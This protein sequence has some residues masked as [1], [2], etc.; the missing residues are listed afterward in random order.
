MIDH[1]NAFISYR[2]APLDS[3]VAAEVQKQLERFRIPIAIRK[4]SGIRKIDRI[5]RDK[6]ELLITSD[7]NETIQQALLHS[8]FLIVICS[9]STRESVW[10]QREIEFFLTTHERSQVLT[11]VAEGEPVDVVPQILQQQEVTVTL[12]SGETETVC[13]PM[14]PLSCDYRGNFRKAR[15]EELPRLAAAMLGCSYDELKRRQRQYR[16]RQLALTFSAVAAGLIALSVYYAWSANQIQKNYEQALINQSQYLSSESLALLE[17]GDRISAILLALEALPKDSQDSRPVLPIAEYALSQAVNAYLPPNNSRYSVENAFFHGGQIQSFCLNDTK[18]HLS[19][20]HSGNTVTVWDVESRQKVYEKVFA[21]NIFK[22]SPLGSSQMLLLTS[23]KLYCIDYLSGS[24]LWEFQV[25]PYNGTHG[26]GGAFALSPGGDSAALMAG[27]YLVIVD[28]GTGKGKQQIPLPTYPSWDEDGQAEYLFHQMAFSHDGRT[29]FFH[30]DGDTDYIAFCDLTE[31]AFLVTPLEFRSVDQVA[32][33]LDGNAVVIGNQRSQTGSYQIGDYYYYSDAYRDVVCMD[34]GGS[35]LWENTLHYSDFCVG[36]DAQAYAFQHPGT[37]CEAIAC[38]SGEM[39][40]IFDATTGE[41]LRQ[42]AFPAVIIELSCFDNYLSL[43]LQDGQLG[44]YLPLGDTVITT[45]CFISELDLS[46]DDES[47]YVS[48]S[49]TGNVLR[50]RYG[51]HDENWQPLELATDSAEIPAFYSLK[52]L[53]SGSRTL[54]YQTNLFDSPFILVDSQNRA[55]SVYEP[56]PETY[57]RYQLLGFDPSGNKLLLTEVVTLRDDPTYILAFDLESKELEP[58]WQQLEHALVGSQSFTFL[59]EGCCY[60]GLYSDDTGAPAYRVVVSDTS[61]ESNAIDIPLLEPNCN[62]SETFIVSPTQD[63]VL[64]RDFAQRYFC[65]DL[66]SGNISHTPSAEIYDSRAVW[67]EDGKQFFL[68]TDN[69]IVQYDRN[70]KEIYRISC[71]GLTPNALYAWDDTLFV[72]YNLDR[73]CRYSIED[74][75]FL[76]QIDV[77]LGGYLSENL[78]WDNSRQGTLALYNDETLCLIDTESWVV[79]SRVESCMGFCL[80]EG[81]TYAVSTDED[82]QTHFGYYSLYDYEDLIAMARQ[83]L[84]DTTLT[85]ELRSRYGL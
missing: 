63:A 35:I 79:R 73:I 26:F 21:L 23:E 4:S 37:G 40:G 34:S 11:V 27:D 58:Q 66:E 76:G 53:R 78:C 69:Y 51:L 20:L 12:D 33:T 42:A 49:A 85:D 83:Q 67:T 65:V 46:L 81:I 56:L 5:F 55:V 6:E 7:L 64:L 29:L 25:D 2:H 61:G 57:S 45:P 38:S 72:L 24:Q 3:K 31:S 68:T 32:F 54:L 70:G 77:E 16:M 41:L 62:L 59:D 30:L 28:T 13:L 80:E 50:Y 10:V 14:E 19:V 60:L 71:K 39:L 8:D 18:T 48:N 52:S 9:T 47:I 75:S 82:G 44:N 1:Y 15:K 74:G 43:I 36:V 84:G 17:E 22:I